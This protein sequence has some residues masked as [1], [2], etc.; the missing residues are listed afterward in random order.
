MGMTLMQDHK[1]IHDAILNFRDCNCKLIHASSSVSE[2]V[3]EHKPWKIQPD[4]ALLN[5]PFNDFNV[6]FT[7]MVSPVTRIAWKLHASHSSSDP[8]P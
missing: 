8:R 2:G 6:S 4:K 5:L 1:D 7:F 3:A